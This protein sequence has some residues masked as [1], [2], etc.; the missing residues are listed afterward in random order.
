MSTDEVR[1]VVRRLFD[2]FYNGG[3]PEIAHEIMAGDVVLH[4]S[5]KDMAG[6]PEVFRQ[7]QIA[8]IAATPDFHMS[9]DDLVVEGGLAAYRWTMSG[10]HTGP[11]RGI[12]PTGKRFS[13]PGMS[14]M[15]VRDGKIVEGWH[16]YDMLGL[17][18]QLGVVPAPG[19]R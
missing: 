7:R 8:Q 12:P 18:Q 2:E 4:D 6:G 14:I 17:L 16:N 13:M 5:G 3:K 9:L 15:R 10:T 1:R 11:M 19:Q